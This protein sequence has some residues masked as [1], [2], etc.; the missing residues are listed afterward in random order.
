MNFLSKLSLYDILAMIVPGFIILL[1]GLSMC[2]LSW[3]PNTLEVD[4]SIIWAIWLIAAY[5]IDIINHL[6]TSR[7]W[8]KT[9]NSYDFLAET[10]RIYAKY[11]D[12]HF[13]ISYFAQ[14]LI[15]IYALS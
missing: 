13:I 9:R 1:W 2:K 10:S 14:K 4:N 15:S 11:D 3:M 7:I 5:L 8:N 12:T 6:L